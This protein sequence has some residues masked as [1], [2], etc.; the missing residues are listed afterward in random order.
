MADDFAKAIKKHSGQDPSEEKQEQ[1]GKPQ[2]VQLTDEYENF[3]KTVISLID[4][5]KIDTKKPSSFINDDIYDSLDDE[6]RAK[7][8]QAIPNIASLLDRIMDFHAR[9]EDD[10]SVE[11]KGLIDM[12][13]QSK[14]RIEE[15]ADVFIF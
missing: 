7:T 11:M 1:L 4:D 13:W 15:H 2:A 8:D 14:Q 12:L 5:G 9:E 10:E 3:L 6:L